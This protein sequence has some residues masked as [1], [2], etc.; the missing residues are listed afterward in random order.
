MFNYQIK[1]KDDIIKN[2]KRLVNR[3]KSIPHVFKATTKHQPLPL[4][5][6]S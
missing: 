6:I 2:E 4:A 5:N 1:K 3:K